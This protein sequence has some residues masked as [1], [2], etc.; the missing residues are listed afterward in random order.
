[1]RT[2]Y[3]LSCTVDASGSIDGFDKTKGSVFDGEDDDCDGRVDED[4]QLPCLIVVND[5]WDNLKKGVKNDENALR[6]VAYSSPNGK[7]SNTSASV[8]DNKYNYSLD[9]IKNRDDSVNLCRFGMLKGEKTDQGYVPVCVPIFKPRDYDFFGDA[10]DSNCDGV[11]Y[12]YKNAVFFDSIGG[13][14]AVGGD[15]SCR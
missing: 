14:D 8:K 6:Y 7:Y 3:G 12:D 1:M 4:A 5:V 13:G 11:D 9:L 2:D 15:K 10:F